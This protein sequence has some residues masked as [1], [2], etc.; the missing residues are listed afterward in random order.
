MRFNSPEAVVEWAVQAVKADYKAHKE[1]GVS[2]NPYSTQGMRSDW[3]R[4]WYNRPPYPWEAPLREYD[5]G[6]Q[7]GRAART[8]WDAIHSSQVEGV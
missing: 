1:H 6:F 3:D 4:G 2:L 8:L 7:R 5:T